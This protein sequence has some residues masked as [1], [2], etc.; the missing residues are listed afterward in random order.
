MHKKAALS[1]EMTT[2]QGLSSSVNLPLY[3]TNKPA[4]Y[5][6]QSASSQDGSLVI[7][8]YATDKGVINVSQ[9]PRPASDP[10]GERVKAADSYTTSVGDARLFPDEKQNPYVVVQTAK[11]W[12]IVRSSNETIL[13]KD[14]KDFCLSLQAVETAK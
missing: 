12:V 5:R 10:Y 2:Y 13:S 4:Q 3:G 8:T 1:P 14:L 7:S 9:Q 11:T 6:F